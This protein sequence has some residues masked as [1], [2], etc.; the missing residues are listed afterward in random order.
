MT[1]A[2]MLCEMQRIKSDFVFFDAE[3]FND[4]GTLPEVYLIIKGLINM[5]IKFTMEPKYLK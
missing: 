4:E 5:K 2:E 1:L 3:S